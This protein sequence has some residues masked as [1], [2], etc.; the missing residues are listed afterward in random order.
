MRQ[1][2]SIERGEFPSWTAYIQVIDPVDAEKYRF[3]IFDL[4]KSWPTNEIP[5]R[6]F[7]KL[8][9]NRNLDEF[10]SE[11][12]QLA[13]SPSHLVPGIEPSPDPTLQ[14]RMFAYPDSQRY[15]LGVNYHSFSANRPKNE[16]HI[17]HR[18]GAGFSHSQYI[19]SVPRV[20]VVTSRLPREKETER[21]TDTDRHGRWARATA[22][23]NLTDE[24]SD[25][26]FVQGRKRWRVIQKA[27]CGQENFVRNVS[28]HLWRA[29]ERVRKD[30]YAMFRRIDEKCGACV[31]RATEDLIAK[32]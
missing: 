22:A 23:L 20:D 28:K 13:F 14:A 26:D 19:H 30:V 31:E 10:F 1:K 32:G 7:G 8:T 29:D 18:D 16:Y 12:E 25:V 6:P 2:T 24:V 5:R 17:Y 3:N 9:L 21:D 27:A 11:N 4:T 15:R